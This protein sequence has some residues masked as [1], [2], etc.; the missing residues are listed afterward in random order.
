MVVRRRGFGVEVK[1]RV[2][3]GSE[4]LPSTKNM[5]LHCVFHVGRSSGGKPVNT[6]NATLCRISSVRVEE[7][8]LNTKNTPTMWACFS[9]LM[10]LLPP[11]HSKRDTKSR[12][13][14]L[15]ALPSWL[16]STATPNT[17]NA[18]LCRIFRARQLLAPTAHPAFHLN[19]ETATV[20]DHHVFRVGWLLSP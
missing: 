12:F 6:Q 16:P 13:G 18:T 2:S 15:L 7:E 9:C 17:K 11:Q 5:M 14:C 10:A 3:G 19:A 20:D 8:L 1:G 4:E